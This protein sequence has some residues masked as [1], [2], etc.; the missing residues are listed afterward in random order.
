[1]FQ[2]SQW[3]L[4]KAIES[5]EGCGERGLFLKLLC[6]WHWEAL[7]LLVLRV[8]D[9]FIIPPLCTWLICS[10][11]D[12][13]NNRLNSPR[14]IHEPSV[15]GLILRRAT[16]TTPYISGLQVCCPAEFSFKLT[17]IFRITPSCSKNTNNSMISTQLECCEHR[18]YTV[19]QT[20]YWYKLNIS[21][22]EHCLYNQT[23]GPEHAVYVWFSFISS[24]LDSF[25]V[26]CI[27][28]FQGETW[29]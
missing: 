12:V 29:Q 10:N 17:K 16:K 14:C 1:M 7:K 18:L 20:K 27:Y 21:A 13:K 4:L 6:C 22:L 3:T 19:L 8:T 2:C 23:E 28:V 11:A 25:F 24:F 15:S 5:S 9:T 26:L